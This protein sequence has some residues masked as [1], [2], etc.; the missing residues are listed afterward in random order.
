MDIPPCGIWYNG[1]R[2][3]TANDKEN[4]IFSRS[5]ESPAN[6]IKHAHTSRQEERMDYGGM[7][8]KTNPARTYHDG[9]L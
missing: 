9:A 4:A 3:Y 5:K 2:H 6:A 1:G 7:G 8:T